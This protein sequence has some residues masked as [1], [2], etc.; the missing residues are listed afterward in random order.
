MKKRWFLGGKRIL[1][2]GKQPLCPQC[3][4]Y[5]DEMFSMA[6]VYEV[7]HYVTYFYSARVPTNGN[8]VCWTKRGSI[9]IRCHY[10]VYNGSYFMALEDVYGYDEHRVYTSTTLDNWEQIGYSQIP[11]SL[12]VWMNGVW[13]VRM[14]EGSSRYVKIATSSNGLEWAVTERSGMRD[15]I[16]DINSTLLSDE[17]GSYYLFRSVYNYHPGWTEPYWSDH[18]FKNSGGIDWEKISLRVPPVTGLPGDPSSA[19]YVIHKVIRANNKYYAYGLCEYSHHIYHPMLLE[20]TDLLNWTNLNFQSASVYNIFV[21]GLAYNGYIFVLLYGA[22]VYTSPDMLNWTMRAI[23]YG[24]NYPQ[25]LEWDSQ[26]SRF[27][28]VIH[29]NYGAHDIYTSPDGINWTTGSN[30]SKTMH[31]LKNTPYSYPLIAW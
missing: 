24:S 4:N 12:P 27:V 30:S 7:D 22:R 23:N 26:A 11:L 31:G 8:K 5:G 9:D 19:I 18:S 21:R 13:T 3:P 16:G 6:A 28:Y 15:T 14:I 29:P 25:F 17:N 10:I 20:S 2:G 1:I